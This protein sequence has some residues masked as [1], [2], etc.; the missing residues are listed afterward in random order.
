MEKKIS[1]AGLK[2]VLSSKEMKNVFGGSGY[3]CYCNCYPN[4]TFSIWGSSC[5]DAIK[6]VAAGCSDGDGG[7]CNNC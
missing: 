3:T 2:K 1:Y 6:Q 7:G 4:Y 5:D